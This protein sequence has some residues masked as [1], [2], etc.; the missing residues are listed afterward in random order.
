M[1]PWATFT[2][3]ASRAGRV[4]RSGGTRASRWTGTWKWTRHGEPTAAQAAASGPVSTSGFAI[5][6]DSQNPEAAWK[7]IEFL[8][9]EEGQAPIVEF[10]EDAPANIAVLNSDAFLEQSWSTNPINMAAL[11]ESA[12]AAFALP[13]S[14]QWNEMMTIFDTN[15]G[16]V[17]A[18]RAEVQPTLDTIQQELVELFSE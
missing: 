12:D 3:A 10:K 2:S 15:L 14:P 9:S 7:V 17:F 6:K 11:G 18:N 1:P 4:V 5:S 16:E 8:T 13:L